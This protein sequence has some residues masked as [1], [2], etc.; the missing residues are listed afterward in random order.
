[1]EA[2]VKL[3]ELPPKKRITY[4]WDYY[5]LW[6]IGGIFVISTLVSSIHQ[7]ITAKDCLLQLIMVNA[8]IP[9]TETVFA[10]DYLTAREYD[11]NEYELIASSAKL[12]MTKE[13]VAEDYQVTQAT[14]ARLTSGDIDIFS[15]PA[16]ILKP[17]LEEG[18]MLSLEDIFTDDELSKYEDYLVYTSDPATKQDYPCAFD[19]SENEWIKSH[20]YY[21]GSC[22]FGILYNCSNVEQAKDFMLYILNY[23]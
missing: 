12:K 7:Y 1:M 15:A 20:G 19:F 3:R 14:I 10:E 18:Y 22:Q 13:S 9:I 16:D 6:I 2:K 8:D 11:L 23:Q 5:K 21:N 17:Y 4:I